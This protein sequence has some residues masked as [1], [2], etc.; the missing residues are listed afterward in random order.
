MEHAAAAQ[1]REH[2]SEGPKRIA[3]NC[4]TCS[5]VFATRQITPC[6]RSWKRR[7]SS[8]GSTSKAGCPAAGRECKVTQQDGA[9]TKLMSMYSANALARMRITHTHCTGRRSHLAAVCLFHRR[10]WQPGSACCRMQYWC[11]YVCRFGGRPDGQ[12]L[13]V[14]TV[15]PPTTTITSTTNRHRHRWPPV[16]YVVSRE[17]KTEVWGSNL[18]STAYSTVLCCTRV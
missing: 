10:S 1:V 18:H 16:Y 6:S 3:G 2:Y 15:P 5:G 12:T 14:I 9:S 13:T 8:R 11:A 4:A 17:R 7:A